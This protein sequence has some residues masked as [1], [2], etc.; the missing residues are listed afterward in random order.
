M[1]ESWWITSV[2]QHSCE[3]DMREY[4]QRAWK[5]SLWPTAI[6]IKKVFHYKLTEILGLK[7]TNKKKSLFSTSNSQERETSRHQK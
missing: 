7:V 6:K 5:D 4:V 2:S 3:D 1:K